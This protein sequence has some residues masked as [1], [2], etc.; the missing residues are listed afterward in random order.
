M[1]N[2]D[3]FRRTMNHLPDFCCHF[4]AVGA[5][6]MMDLSLKME[7]TNPDCQMAANVI[8]KD[9]AQ[10]EQPSDPTPLCPQSNL[11]ELVR[12]DAPPSV[13]QKRNLLAACRQNCH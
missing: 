4:S 6:L 10:S 5:N 3:G 11:S 7:S 9:T 13:T 8:T 12:E 1:K 2:Q